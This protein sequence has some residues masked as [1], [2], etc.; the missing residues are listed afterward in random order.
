MFA[1]GSCDMSI[2]IWD[3]RAKAKGPSAKSCQ[4][5]LVGPQS[6][7][8]AVEWMSNSTCLGAGGDDA[9]I[10]IFDIRSPHRYLLKLDE[11]E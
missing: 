7:V 6:D 5:S 3:I 1:S 8:K 10:F 4:H 9:I 11:R 2:K